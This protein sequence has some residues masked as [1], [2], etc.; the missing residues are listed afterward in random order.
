MINGVGFNSQPLQELMEPKWTVHLK[1]A[2]CGQNDQI[3]VRT[4]LSLL[5]QS[6]GHLEGKVT[7]CGEAVSPLSELVAVLYVSRKTVANHT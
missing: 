4:T 6:Y 2:H 3:P 1:G 7:S 5:S